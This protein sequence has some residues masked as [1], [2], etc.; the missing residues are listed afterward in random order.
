MAQ[1]LTYLAQFRLFFLFHFINPAVE[2]PTLKQLNMCL[3]NGSLMAMFI[4]DKKS[5]ED[6]IQSPTALKHHIAADISMVLQ[7]TLQNHFPIGPVYQL[8]ADIT[9]PVIYD[10][11]H[12][13]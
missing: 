7:V 4:K 1:W 2:S 12:P 5:K 11:R 10:G 9:S 13:K 3:C 8:L 6:I